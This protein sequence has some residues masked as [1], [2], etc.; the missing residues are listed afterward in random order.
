[1]PRAS[2][3]FVVFSALLASVW[4]L[5]LDRLA[6][7]VAARPPEGPA[8]EFR[9]ITAD[10]YTA[11]GTGTMNVGANSPIII[12]DAD[13]MIVDSHITPASARVLLEELKTITDKPVRFVV[14]THYHFDHTHGNQ[15]F[16]PDVAIIGHEFTRTMLLS[17]VLEQRTYRSFT[18]NLPTQNE[19]LERRIQET[20]NAAERQALED[21]LYVQQNYVAELE[22]VE[23]T[24]PNLTLRTMMTIY[25]G[26][27]EIQLH[28]FGRG[29]TGGDVVV[30]LPQERIICTGDLVTA[31]LAY[32]GDGHVDEWAA[33]LDG[34]LELD[35]E[36]VLPGHGAPFTGR[37]TVE[38]FRGYLTDLWSQ[39][40]RLHNEG[41]SPEQA[42][43]RVDMTS[44]REHYSDI[45]G[46]GVDLRS[47]ERIYEVIEG[48]DMPI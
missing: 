28:F 32:M 39:V 47:V 15:V 23:P 4:A 41:V 11:M 33:T 38:N 14:N 26:S 43:R 44:H 37:Q 5:D 8:Y 24:P 19:E 7:Q 29:H 10:I 35:F 21:R 6:G 42:A 34:L 31:G 1:M 20:L 18:E 48:N 25:R 46:P 16:D 27:R 30:Y 22:D 2:L 36:T 9:Q 40:S 17:N 3:A 13:V 45:Q 12:N